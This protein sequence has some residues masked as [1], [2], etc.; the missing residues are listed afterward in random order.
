MT[1]FE[2]SSVAKR[3]KEQT[4]EIMVKLTEYVNRWNK[5]RNKHMINSEEITECFL[6]NDI[7]CRYFQNHK[8]K[9]FARLLQKYNIKI[10]AAI[11]L[12]TAFIEELS[13]NLLNNKNGHNPMIQLKEIQKIVNSTPWNKIPVFCINNRNP[14]KMTLSI[15]QTDFIWNINNFINKNRNNINLRAMKG[16]Y[17]Y[18]WIVRIYENVDIGISFKIKNKI[19]SVNGI[20]LDKEDIRNKLIISQPKYDCLHKFVSNINELIIIS[21]Q[22]DADQDEQESMYLETDWE[23]WRIDTIDDKLDE[24]LEDMDDVH[25]DITA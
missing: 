10:S 2:S 24:K 6:K 16:N 18:I 1:S 22:M 15:K 25:S 3:Q 12:W 17:E 7:N 11:N 23:E 19:W 14:T 9:D 5:G 13:G 4:S 21:D 8:R 20:Y